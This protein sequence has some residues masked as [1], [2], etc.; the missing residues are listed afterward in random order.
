MILSI[1]FN[2]VSRL[3]YCCCCIPLTSLF[4]IVIFLITRIIKLKGT[5]RSEISFLTNMRIVAMNENE[6]GGRRYRRA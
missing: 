6:I 4:L 3:W 5:I 1:P 2:F